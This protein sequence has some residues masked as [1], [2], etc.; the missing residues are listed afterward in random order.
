MEGF[1]FQEVL[2]STKKSRCKILRWS[3]AP[4]V[5]VHQPKKVWYKQ[6]PSFYLSPGKKELAHHHTQTPSHRTTHWKRE[7]GSAHMW[8]PVFGGATTDYTAWE[9]KTEEFAD[10]QLP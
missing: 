6:Q 2:F 3:F 5:A 10:E 4:F 7:P 9:G 8:H 1:Q